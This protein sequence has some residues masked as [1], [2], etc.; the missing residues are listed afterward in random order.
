MAK[1]Q[2]E[3]NMLAFFNANKNH[4]FVNRNLANDA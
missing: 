2:K 3:D 1:E 4:L